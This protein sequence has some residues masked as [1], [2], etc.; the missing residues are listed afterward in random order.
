MKNLFSLLLATVC[1]VGVTVQANAADKIFASDFSTTNS[2][3]TNDTFNVNVRD[4][5]AP[6]GWKTRN[7][8]W[9]TMQTIFGI[10]NT[11]GNTGIDPFYVGTNK[12]AAMKVLT[13][14]SA[15]QL[16]PATNG[17]SARF[18]MWQTNYDGTT[19]SQAFSQVMAVT[20]KTLVYNTVDSSGAEKP[21]LNIGYGTNYDGVLHVPAAS[22][23]QLDNGTIKILN[24]YDTAHNMRFTWVSPGIAKLLLLG[25][26]N[27]FEID[28]SSSQRLW[29]V[30]NSGNVNAAGYLQPQ[31][32]SKI[33]SGAGVPTNS[34]SVGSIYLRTDGTNA[35]TVFYVCTGTTNWTAK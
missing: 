30:D 17:G 27:G 11:N 4:I 28:G 18:E 26:S 14:G 19:N 9:G 32:G 35:N 25:N 31:A 34:A 22:G 5:S 3:K 21:F 8:T 10:L 7:V 20:N 15:F 23:L 13:N 24:P 16:Y 33:F 29:S 12:P 2:L 1:A 6:T